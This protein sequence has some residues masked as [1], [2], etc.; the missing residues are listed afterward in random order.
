MALVDRAELLPWNGENKLLDPYSEL[1][2]LCKNAQLPNRADSLHCKE[3][4]PTVHTSLF[5]YIHS[6]HDPLGRHV[7]VSL[8]YWLLCMWQSR[9]N[10]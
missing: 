3:L 7:I 1:G 2:H 9:S 10:C 8:F 6:E 4:R 5:K